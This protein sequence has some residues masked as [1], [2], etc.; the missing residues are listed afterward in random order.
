MGKN[1][2]GKGLVVGIIWLTVM[3]T[4]LI[5]YTT[6]GQNQENLQSTNTVT[7]TPWVKPCKILDAWFLEESFRFESPFFGPVLITASGGCGINYQ[8]L[9]LS[10]NVP[11]WIGDP[12]SCIFFV[13]LMLGGMPGGIALTGFSLTT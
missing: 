3:L 9:P 6:V 7:V 12:G 2:W 13:P 4:I 11:V 8:E 5:P 1:I 10:E